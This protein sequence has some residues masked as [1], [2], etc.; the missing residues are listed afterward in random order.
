MK[1]LPVR[2]VY[3]GVTC[4]GGVLRCYCDKGQ[5]VIKDRL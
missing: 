5:T 4:E 3:E 1:V 2:V